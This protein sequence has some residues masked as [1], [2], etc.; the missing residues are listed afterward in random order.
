MSEEQTAVVK[1]EQG[2]K[3]MMS[4]GKAGVQIASLD[5]AYR[6]A[7]YVV[8][9]GFAPRGLEKPESVLIAMQHGAELGMTPMQALQ[10]IAI[11][12]GRP[13]I[14]GDAALALV[15]GSGLCEKYSQS[16]IGTGDDR[17]AVVYTKRKDDGSEVTTE[18]SV[19][20]AKRAGLWGK[21]GPWSQYPERMLLFR[22]RGFNLRDNFGDV[23]KGLRTDAEIEDMPMKEATGIE[24]VTPEVMP[25][26]QSI[27]DR[28]KAAQQ[29]DKKQPVTIDHTDPPKEEQHEPEEQHAPTQDMSYI[30]QDIEALIESMKATRIAA[31]FEAVGLDFAA[32]PFELSDDNA[33][34]LKSALV[35]ESKN[36]RK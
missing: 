5:E 14:Y 19:G 26:K 22:A 36:V 23:L 16:T 8:A 25:P 10:S 33:V 27:R 17:K 28:A 6:F 31:A 12:N 11:V 21:Q 15:R 13:A 9:A 24:V 34:A 2:N 18:F 29:Q 35:A 32:W 4:Y 20:D 30:R 3:A 1:Q 7:K